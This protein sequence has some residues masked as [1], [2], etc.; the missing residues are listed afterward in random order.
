ML[1]AVYE[2]SL[3]CFLFPSCMTTPLKSSLLLT[4]QKIGQYPG[5]F[6]ANSR[7]DCRFHVVQQSCLKFEIRR[8][9]FQ[10][11]VGR[12]LVS[13]QPI[14]PFDTFSWHALVGDISDGIMSVQFNG[15]I[16]FSFLFL[17]NQSWKVRARK[18]QMCAFFIPSPL[19]YCSM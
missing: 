9:V 3:N 2:N 6:K 11:Y 12:K 17:Q 10:K 13:S 4:L 16:F 1:N 7:S 15:T 14:I 19:L 18:W 5:R 8:W